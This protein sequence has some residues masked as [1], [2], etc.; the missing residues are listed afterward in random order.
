[1]Q[2]FSQRVSLQ[3]GMEPLAPLLTELTELTELGDS[4][5]TVAGGGGPADSLPPCFWSNVKFVL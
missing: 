5:Q 3:A 4:Q 1:M 2:T